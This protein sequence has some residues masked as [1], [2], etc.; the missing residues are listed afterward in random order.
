MKI[1]KQRL[2]QIIRE[3]T[4]G[5]FKNL[6]T[7]SLSNTSLR[8]QRRDRGEGGEG[9][10]P[11]ENGLINQIEEFLAK[12]ANKDGV[13]LVQHKVLFTRIIKYLQDSILKSAKP[14]APEAGEQQ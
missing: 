5:Q 14:E 3:E 12:I 13:D 4:E 9:T 6:N 10:T 2:L 8:Q 7:K 11:Q 1:S